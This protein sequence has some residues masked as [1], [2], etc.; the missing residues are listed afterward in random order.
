MN[1]RFSDEH[2][3]P[4]AGYDDPAYPAYDERR[5]QSYRQP[6][7]R[8]H[9]AVLEGARFYLRLALSTFVVLT[10]SYLTVRLLASCSAHVV[11][12]GTWI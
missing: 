4:E 5:P 12:H 2:H 7:S 6:L 1:K 10:A 11:D 8:R 9:A 3:Q